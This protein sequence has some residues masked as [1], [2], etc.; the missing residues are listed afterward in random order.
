MERLPKEQVDFIKTLD[1]KQKED[2]LRLNSIFKND[3]TLLND[4]VNELKKGHVNY[5]ES[6]SLN[7]DRV[8][9]LGNSEDAS[10]YEA[11]R[12]SQK[13]FGKGAAQY[14]DAV[15]PNSPFYGDEERKQKATKQM[16]EQ[17]RTSAVGKYI[18]PIPLG[19]VS[20]VANTAAGVAQT[21]S[22][23][24]D[25]ALDTD[26]LETV[27]KALPYWNLDEVYGDKDG[28]SAKLTSLLVQ[29][30]TGFGVARKV[31]GKIVNKVLEKKLAKEAATKLALT[32]GGK[33]I[34]DV[35][36][37]GGYWLLPA[38]AGDFL[39]S[40]GEQK[41]LGDYLGKEG[42]E[43]K[44]YSP[45]QDALSRTITEDIEK[46][47]DPKERAAAI[48][49]N[50]LKFAAEGTAFLGALKL[51]GVGTKLTGK[52]I[53]APLLVGVNKAVINPI[54]KI[55]ASEKTGLPTVA[56]FL[57]KAPGA[58]AEKIGIPKYDLWKFESFNKGWGPA[59]RRSLEILS[60]K[61]LSGGRFDQAS[62][63]AKR[64]FAGRILKAKKGVDIFIKDLDKEMY[65]LAK[66]GFQDI[67][68]QSDTALKALQKW[69][70]VLAYMRGELDLK[71]LPKTLQ[72]SA[73][74]L[75]KMID[76]QTK[77][78][79]PYVTDKDIR[80][81]L[82]K[83]M[84][85]YLHTSYEIFKNNKYIPDPDDVAKATQYFVN[86]ISKT[87]P[88]GTTPEQILKQAETKVNDILDIGRNEGTSPFQ[89]VKN[90]TKVTSPDGIL[91]D[92]KNVPDEIAK[93]IG[94]VTD[95][96]NII[97][98]T[99][100]EQAKAVETLKMYQTIKDAGLGKWIFRSHK[101][102][103]D[104]LLEN[105]IQGTRG[106]VPITVKQPYNLD[107]KGIFSNADG[108]DLFTLPEFARA[109]QGDTLLTDVF[110]R[111][112]PYKFLLTMKGIGQINK[113]VL[114]VMTQMRNITTASMFALANGHIGSGGSFL[115]GFKY[116]MDD[117]V[118][119]TIDPKKLKSMLDEAL[120][121][122]AL[123]SSVIAQE[124]EMLIPQIIKQKNL[125]IIKT[126]EQWMSYLYRNPIVAKATELYQLGDN[127]WKL[128][129]Y[130]YTK[131]QLKPAITKL[132]DAIK[133]FDEV[134]G[135]K[136][137]PFKADATNKI[138]SDE[139][140]RLINIPSKNL[141]VSEDVKSVIQYIKGEIP[142]EKV[143]K[144]FRD[145]LKNSDDAIKEM[146][147]LIMRDV[148]PNYSMIPKAVQNIRQ[149][150]LFG[151]FVG[152]T[153][154]M[155]R[156]TFHIMRRGMNEMS[157]SNPY[158]RQMGA[159]RLMG[160][161]GTITTATPVAVSAGITAT[162]IA[163]EKLDAFTKY[164][165]A[166]YEKGASFMPTKSQDPKNK[167]WEQMNLSF[168]NPYDSVA[169]PFRYMFNNYNSYSK[170]PDASLVERLLSSLIGTYENPGFIMGALKPFIEPAIWS[171]VYMD[172]APKSL[173][174]GRG[175]EDAKGNSIYDIEN[176]G[177]KVFE[178]VLD[179]IFKKLGPTTLLSTDKIV[180]ASFGILSP[181]AVKLD[182]F[183]EILALVLGI[184]IQTADAMKSFR[185]QTGGF[186]EERGKARGT[187]LRNSLRADELTI[188]P[189][190]IIKEFDKYQ[191][192]NYRIWT[193][194]YNR[195]QALRTIGYNDKEI[196]KT[197]EGRRAFSKKELYYLM[198]GL[199]K[200]ANEPDSSD[201]KNTGF[202]RRVD[203]INEAEGTNYK[204]RDLIR[205]GDLGVIKKQWDKLP[206][207]MDLEAREETSKKPSYSR[208][209]DIPTDIVPIKP[210]PITV[211]APGP[212]SAA[213]M[214]DQNLLASTTNFGQKFGLQN[215]TPSGLSRTEEALLSPTEKLIAQRSRGLS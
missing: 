44:W 171:E 157:S 38:A 212:Q 117:V 25:L 9:D 136:F 175:G 19:I 113:T 49:R 100:V 79:A 207:G 149:F 132:D 6:E 172:L 192:N 87:A 140:A 183:K 77:E 27:Q 125:G 120:E 211:T 11:L 173:P 45:A 190:N 39:V 30:G 116:M 130:N 168:S 61:V 195:I 90:I 123:D 42:A 145:G 188:N 214:P 91:K 187:F 71:E 36:K 60:D 17:F 215:L 69:D 153:S 75:R 8:R 64:T 62:I 194:V 22:A 124:L 98:D 29:Y 26:T 10:K 156:N 131:S 186:S 134:E 34:S 82:I 81:E 73:A 189:S 43:G 18:A 86:L 107:L 167:T 83:N 3:K 32:K 159:R 119:K 142:L 143:S 160:G 50:K 185:R 68:F 56:R 46:I 28:A 111:S 96:K 135:V 37:F 204:V 146:S 205:K 94:K 24:S 58:I 154:E 85:K 137:N 147:G 102:F 180:D 105:K 5:L 2:L 99:V 128:Y 40:T 112:A 103:D 95:P 1:V 155:Y 88:K 200:S 148:Y 59:V 162:G 78:L 151:N 179:H 110:M 53:A 93:L 115:D 150:P 70:N 182:P 114:S 122:G 133:Y 20:G 118:G 51:T 14:Y 31:T 72:L 203:E 97:M 101:E 4:Y 47:Q 201:I 21:L 121:V 13:L 23:L 89:R 198:K 106:I 202:K 15:S 12:I 164:F 66:V 52:Y 161:V 67:A 63:N 191:K 33:K 48:L 74:S 184:R 176:D 165:S 196:Y 109:I 209:Q 84:G 181:S 41:T 178:K 210:E 92:V 208:R 206:L 129:G 127:V 163:K 199:Y 54:V 197:L 138:S 174:F 126:T 7:M 139:I 57:K 169:L 108:S 65:K 170:I 16:S 55:A 141:K 80:A 213:P 152:F 104:F 76:K 166:P 177:D 158:I 35:A 193:N 144:N